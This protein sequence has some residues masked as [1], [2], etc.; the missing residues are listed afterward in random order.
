MNSLEPDTV[1]LCATCTHARRV[2]TPRSVFILCEKSRVDSSYE[3][4]PR[5]P[6]RACP[7]YEPEREGKGVGLA[8]ASGDPDTK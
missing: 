1:G 3:R 7:G 6:M 2:S 5:L 4:Y 8:G